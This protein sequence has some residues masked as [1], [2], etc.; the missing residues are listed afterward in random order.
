MARK[1]QISIEKRAAI[2]ALH[3]EGLSEREIASRLNVSCKG[4]HYTIV[5]KRETGQLS[6]R[7]RIG[8]PRATTSAEDNYIIT[9]SKR[10][11]RLTAPEIT[12]AVNENRDKN[13]SVTTVK[14]RLLAAGLRG[15]VAVRKPLL[16][17]IHK[18]NRLAW[19]RRHSNWSIKQWKKVLWTGESKFEIFGFKRRA[20]VRRKPNERMAEQCLVPTVKHG[21]GNVMVWGCFAGDRVGDLVKIEGIMRKE[22]YLKILQENAVP[23]GRR[24][25]G[26]NFVFQQDNDLKHSSRLCKSHLEQR[27]T[28]G[29]LQIMVWPSQSPDLSPIELLWDELDR[30]AKQRLPQNENMLWKYLQDAWQQITPDCLMNLIERMPRICNAVICAKGGHIDEKNL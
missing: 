26:K 30:K 24:I 20:Y 4:V 6:D 13:I 10:N 22:Q 16:K 5:R 3:D 2:C 25:A 17:P 7:K 19:A 21:G 12:H 23:S 15:C 27:K 8:R 18:K 9:T 28:A 11:R 29:E 14:T 1:N